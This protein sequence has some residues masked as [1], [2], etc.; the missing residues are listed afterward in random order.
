MKGDD[1]MIEPILY[2]T[3]GLGQELYLYKSPNNKKIRQIETGIVYDEA[4]DVKDSS[5][6]FRYHYEE[7]NE[8]REVIDNGDNENIR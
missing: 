6:N 7:T 4:I 5:G 1:I 2:G 3:N 8:E